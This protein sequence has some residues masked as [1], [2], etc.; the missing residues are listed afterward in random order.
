M[1]V[2]GGAS[3]ARASENESKKAH[4]RERNLGMGG[5]R[6]GAR[7]LV[8]AAYLKRILKE[9]SVSSSSS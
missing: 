6:H 3:F 5:M 8:Q 2:R 1:T 9:T 4:A 7:V